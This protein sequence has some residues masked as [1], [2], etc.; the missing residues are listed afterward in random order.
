MNEI[1]KKIKR[2]IVIYSKTSLSEEKESQCNF[3]NFRN[4]LSC[5]RRQV[6]FDFLLVVVFKCR[7]PRIANKEAGIYCNFGLFFNSHVICLEDRKVSVG[8]FLVSKN[9][10]KKQVYNLQ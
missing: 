4:H 7:F 1:K 2:S 10:R 8:I 6:S 3:L 5:S 9:E